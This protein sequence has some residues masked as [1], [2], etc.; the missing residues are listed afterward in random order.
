MATLALSAAGSVVGSTLLPNGITAFG[1]TIAGSTIGSQVGALAGSFVDEALFGSAG[2]SRTYE[3]PRLADLRVTT[4]TEGATIP[5]LYGRAR[6]GGQIIW[7]TD[8]EEEVVTTE[9]G[10]GGK[11]GA[12]GGGG[13]SST[14]YLYYANFAVALCEG[15]I[16]GIGRVWA[17]GNEWDLSN[18][19]YRLYTGSE[20]QE[21]DSLIEAR[22]GQSN[23]PAYRGTAYVVFERL[24]LQSFGNRLPQLSFEVFRA[25]DDLHKRI[26]GA[27]IIP[28]AGEFAY[29]TQ[30]VTRDGAFGERIAENV[31]TREADTDWSASME[32]MS[33]TLPNIGSASLIVSWFGTDLRAAHCEIRPCVDRTAKDTR[34]LVWSVAGESR[35]TARVVSTHDGRPAFGGTPSDE[36]V[37][38]AIQDLKARGMQAVLTP[39]ILMDIAETNTLP[40]P[41]SGTPVQPAYP[42]RGRITIDPAPGQP[43]SPD[44]TATAAGQIAAFVGSAAPGDFQVAGTGVTYSGPNEWSYRRFILHNAHLALAAGG[45]DAFVIGTEMRA[46]TWSRDAQSSYPFVAALQQLASDVKQILGPTTKVTYAADW[47]EYFGHQPNDGSGDVA[48]HLDPL[49]A[50][51][52][53]DAVGVDLYWPLADW[54]EGDQHLDRVEAR[55]IYDIAYLKSNLAGGEGYD[56]YYAND[57]DRTAQ[58]RSPITDGAGGK[59]WVYRFKDMPNW[60][61][62]QH[63]NRPG[64]IEQGTPTAWVPR[65]KPVWLMEIGCPA[66]DKGANQPNVFFDPK[67]SESTLPYFASRRRDDAMQR[68]YLQAL[69]EGLDPDHAGYVD[70]TNPVSDQYTGRM[71]DLDRIHIYAWDARPHPAF[72]NDQTSWSD[73]DNWI[74]G[75]WLN[76]R[77]S[78]PPLADTLRQ[79]LLDY[80]FTDVEL[81]ALDG[82][83]PGYLI[84]RLMAPREALQ[85]LELAYFLDAIESA[86]RIAF[87]HRA[88]DLPVATLPWDALASANQ[89]ARLL[90]R[91]RG[92]E[93]E[94]P[95]TAKISHVNAGGDYRK[96]VAEA[97]KL[98]GFS[99]RVATADLPIMLDGEQAQSIA[100]T[101][102]HEAWAAR[103]RTTFALPPSKLAIEPGDLLET[104]DEDGHRLRHRVIEIN[105]RGLR[106]VSGQSVDPSVYRPQEAPY[107]GTALAAQPVVG[108]ADALFLDL[109][110]L[111]GDAAPTDGLIALHQAPWP[112]PLAVYRSP[113]D[114]GFALAATAVTPA[115]IGTLLDPWPGGPPARYDYAT[116]V[117]VRLASGTLRSVPQLSLFEGANALAVRRDDG[118]FEVAQFANADLVD[119]LTYELYGFLRGQLGTDIDTDHTQTLAAAGAP[120][121]LLDSR[122]TR[123]PLSED[124]LRRSFNWRYGPANRD[125]GHQSYAETRHAF[126]GIARRPLSPVHVRAHRAAGDIQLSWIRR[127]RIGGDN[128]EIEEVALGE[129]TEAYEVDILNGASVVRTLKSQIPNAMYSS[130]QQTMDFGAPQASIS[131]IVY[132]MSA[133]YGRGAPRQVVV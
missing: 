112:G 109:P 108:V 26:K 103:E 100:T 15:E 24:P 77:I 119:A 19:A 32:Q 129:E 80:D 48:F 94:L 16:T 37:V 6:I 93:T 43:A 65:S 85:P 122:L 31:H 18:V 113:G 110:L 25:V 104:V 90:T 45:V 70:G 88:A 41:Y 46:L 47:S 96:S 107:R 71:I 27:V 9:A 121:V 81:S 83:V 87:R 8:F 23:A 17:D 50:S 106:E 62:N 63:F 125:I 56:W 132:Q 3:G 114:D 12:L 49:W 4:S 53:I 79:I 123:I 89:E 66:I 111:T 131:I 97:R 126:Q 74:Y 98:A 2:Q 124:A 58:V 95:A 28:G 20:T 128:W 118:S 82:L 92:Q 59:P 60:W 42:W 68:A 73:G 86:D 1:A 67:S 11:G 21:A 130:A 78:S 61:S 39:F 57:T 51:P 40:D 72:P 52:S 84:N 64:G 75:H 14:N 30:P 99:E 29:A 34:P 101:W 116:R 76:G 105:D 35:V 55:S 127:T 69:I 10:G 7:A 133:Q 102:L 115:V 44:K 38:Q 13:A 91:K 36:S 22:L 54:R 33:R 117:R 120:I 5:R